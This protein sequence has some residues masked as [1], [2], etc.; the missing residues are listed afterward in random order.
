VAEG[1]T[2]AYSP[3]HHY[4]T[5][6]TGGHYVLYNVLTGESRPLS[7]PDGVVPE[8]ISWSPDNTRFTY[9]HDVYPDTTGADS[10]LYLYDLNTGQSS[11]IYTAPS[12]QFS[13]TDIDPLHATGKTYF[14][15]SSCAVSWLDRDH[16][17]FDRFTGSLPAHI[18]VPLG[19][20]EPAELAPNTESLAALISPT[21]VDFEDFPKPD[22]GPNS[23]EVED[24]APTS[25]IA[26]LHYSTQGCYGCVALAK[27]PFD[28]T[29]LQHS[30][31]LP[32]DCEAAGFLPD[33]SLLVNSGPANA[34]I[35][36]TIDTQALKER[37]LFAI[38]ASAAI[39]LAENPAPIRDNNWLTPYWRG[40]PGHGAEIFEFYFNI[41]LTVHGL[42]LADLTTGKVSNL[43]PAPASNGETVD[44]DQIL[45]WL[46]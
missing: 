19:G 24:Y 22:W 30:I 15:R 20:G 28:L 33:G 26:L 37:Q 45:A 23:I 31:K 3:D 8:C 6:G 35:V 1:A 18:S 44:V 32:C 27:P 13:L 5:Y 25:G 16:F 46:P 41:G 2:V 10:D 38:D 12:A 7:F 40:D 39:N 21:V 14:G 17:L 43:T 34:A 11:K 4:I 42:V 29:S 36:G 9:K